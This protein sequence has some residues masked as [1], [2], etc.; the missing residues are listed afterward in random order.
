MEES[1]IDQAL[2]GDPALKSSPAPVTQCICPIALAAFSQGQPVDTNCLA[3][4]PNCGNGVCESGETQTN[5]PSDCGSSGPVC[6]NGRCESGE[7]HTSCPSD[8]GPICGNGLCESGE[9]S[10]SCPSDCGT[11]GGCLNRVPCI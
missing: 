6:G 9:T 3:V 8:C 7:T 10:S 11:G 4:C 5:C 2:E 1:S